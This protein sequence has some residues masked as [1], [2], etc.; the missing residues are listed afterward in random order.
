MK[1]PAFPPSHPA[2]ST[3]CPKSHFSDSNSLSARTHAVVCNMHLGSIPFTRASRPCYFAS[4]TPAFT[5]LPRPQY[6]HTA[7]VV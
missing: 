7:F 4:S 2:I 6:T 5:P 3:P 1:L